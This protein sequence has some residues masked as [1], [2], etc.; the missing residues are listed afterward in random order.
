M[1]RVRRKDEGEVSLG[2]TRRRTVRKRAGEPHPL[3]RAGARHPDLDFDE[4]LKPIPVEK[5]SPQGDAAPASAP[6][7]PPTPPAT[8]KTSKADFPAVLTWDAVRTG[9]LP[10][11]GSGLPPSLERDVP[12]AYRFWKAASAEDAL[13]VREALVESELFT[14]DTVRLVNGEPRR[15]SFEP[16]VKMYLPPS[17]DET[18]PVVVPAP[19]RPIEKA[20]ALLVDSETPVA[21]FD[22]DVTAA[23]GLDTLL[24]KTA[25]LKTDWVIA[26]RDSETV[27]KVFAPAFRLRG[28]TDLLFATSADLENSDAVEWITTDRAG[29]LVKF[30]RERDIRILKA[31]TANEE[32]IVVGVVLEPDE[33]DAQ[34]DTISKEEIRN[35]AH[36]FMEEFQVSGV[37]HKEFA[38][39]RLKILESWIAP[40]SFEMEGQAVKE[41]SWLM[42]K[43]VVDDEL[44][45]AAKAGKFT[46]FSIGG[47]AIRK[48]VKA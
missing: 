22:E 37:Q 44:W 30:A 13:L 10:A 1:A 43:R 42:T 46:G 34:G 48:P 23:L 9:Q 24:E 11:E 25:K 5:A 8:V 28:R 6:A 33:V 31:K 32:R 26:V 41:G 29:A 20:A 45:K 7:A 47:S 21:L 15:V 19:R 40:V 14:P 39:G 3:G 12:P 4:G 16:V 2:E 36:R 38:G 18:E 35:A 17:Y 27:R